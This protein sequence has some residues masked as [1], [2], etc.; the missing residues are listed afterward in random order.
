MDS[1]ICSIGST[2]NQG[3][4][5]I[6]MQRRGEREKSRFAIPVMP[7]PLIIVL[8]S[9]AGIHHVDYP[10]GSALMRGI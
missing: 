5:K 7:T 4:F 6:R 3:E 2:S 1:Q 8:Y 9:N 10:S